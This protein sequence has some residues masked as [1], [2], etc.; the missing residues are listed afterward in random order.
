MFPGIVVTHLK[1][2]LFGLGMTSEGGGAVAFPVLT[3]AFDT[4]PKTARDVALLVQGCGMS[5][6]TFAIFFMKVL[7][8]MKSKVTINSLSLVN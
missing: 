8:G 4:D 1:F 7:I 2:D 6:A 3:L 5:C